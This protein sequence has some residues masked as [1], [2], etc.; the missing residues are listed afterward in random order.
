MWTNSTNHSWTKEN[1]S[2][3]ISLTLISLSWIWVDFL[4][5]YVVLNRVP[6]VLSW[7]VQRVKPYSLYTGT[8]VLT[9]INTEHKSLQSLNVRGHGIVVQ[10]KA[11]RPFCLSKQLLILFSEHLKV[12]W[13]IRTLWTHVVQQIKKQN[14]SQCAFAI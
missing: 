9:L 3:L 10:W 13:R 12:K 14:S 8:V 11:G 4:F 6:R 7:E 5:M 2:Q 1:N